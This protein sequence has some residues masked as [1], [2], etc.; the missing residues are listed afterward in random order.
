MVVTAQQWYSIHSCRS[1]SW[2]FHIGRS[3]LSLSISPSLSLSFFFSLSLFLSRVARTVSDPIAVP[4]ALWGLPWALGVGPESESE[5]VSLVCW[6]LLWV[7]LFY[8]SFSFFIQLK[9]I[10]HIK[11]YRHRISDV[12]SQFPIYIVLWAVGCECCCAALCVMLKPHDSSL[13]PTLTLKQNQF[14]YSSQVQANQ[15]KPYTRRRRRL[16]HRLH[17]LINYLF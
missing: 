17:S 7:N 4:I 10:F 12:H 13:K 8:F 3:S 2:H 15:T 11:G 1:K 14:K 5:W 6:S 16:R 9:L